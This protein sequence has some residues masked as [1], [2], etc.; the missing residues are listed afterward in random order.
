MPISDT[1]YSQYLKTIKLRLQLDGPTDKVKNNDYNPYYNIKNP[2]KNVKNGDKNSTI[3]IYLLLRYEIERYYTVPSP[4]RISFLYSVLDQNIP[5]MSPFERSYFYDSLVS[6]SAGIVPPVNSSK[7]TSG[8]SLRNVR[9]CEQAY[10]SPNSRLTTVDDVTYVSAL[11]NTNNYA[12]YKNSSTNTVIIA[13]RGTDVYRDVITDYWLLSGYT[14]DARF[15]DTANIYQ[16][17]KNTP[18]YAGWTIQTTGHS[19]G[20]CLGLYLNFLYGI[21]AD[22]FDPAIGRNMFLNNPNKSNATAHIVKGD[23]VSPLVYSNNVVGTL[24]IYP[25]ENTNYGYYGYHLRSNFYNPP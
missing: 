14:T 17:I 23:I 7:L 10:T 6:A 24:N 13:F 1:S 4:S 25:V 19:L 3:E 22:V 2:L 12:V 8:P 15:Q 9:L 5:Q 18:E 21:T 11:S 16:T 20:G